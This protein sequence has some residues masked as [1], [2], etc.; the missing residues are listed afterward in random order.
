[1]IITTGTAYDAVSG[2][3]SQPYY[4]QVSTDGMAWG[5]YDSGWIVSSYTWTGLT[6]NTTYWFR[7]KAKDVLLNESSYTN[8]TG[9]ST[10]A[11]P[12]TGSFV[13]VVDLY[14]VFWTHS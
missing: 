9:K 7:I 14:P 2:L 10:L 8:A 3:N 5:N 13:D 12:P 6:S 11:N 4:I 1:V